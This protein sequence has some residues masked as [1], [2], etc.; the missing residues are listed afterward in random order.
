MAYNVSRLREVG[1]IG[2]E[3]F[4]L[5]EDIKINDNSTKTPIL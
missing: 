4:L 3:Y 1:E 5:N 2:A